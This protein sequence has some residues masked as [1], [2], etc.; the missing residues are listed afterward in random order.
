MQFKS[1]ITNF[2]RVLQKKGNNW[3]V[4]H[5]RF[6]IHKS[7]QRRVCTETGVINLLSRRRFRIS[8]LEYLLYISN[9]V[10]VIIIMQSLNSEKIKFRLHTWCIQRQYLWQQSLSVSVLLAK[11]RFDVWYKT[12][13]IF[14]Q[15]S[16]MLQF[17]ISCAIIQMSKV[18]IILY[19]NLAVSISLGTKRLL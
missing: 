4:K 19:I 11:Q 9:L 1:S 15:Y 8:M 3:H 6:E 7:N 13:Y 18:A 17:L 12:F 2:C 10:H 16:V 5:M 14:S